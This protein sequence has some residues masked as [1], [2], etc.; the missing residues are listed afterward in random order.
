MLHYFSYNILHFLIIFQDYE[1]AKMYFS[2]GLSFGQFR[3]AMQLLKVECHLNPI[4]SFPYI[5]TL[6]MIYEVFPSPKRRLIILTQMILYYY[7]T[8]NPKEL[9]N[10]LKLFLDQD[11]ED[12]LKKQQLIVSEIYTSYY[13]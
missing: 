4:D 9:I 13:S 1:K 3:C 2:R 8:E 6:K 7:D 11:I 12:T 10:T 5:K